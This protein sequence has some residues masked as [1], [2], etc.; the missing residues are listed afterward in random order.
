MS[1]AV[2]IDYEDGNVAPQWWRTFVREG[3]LVGIVAMLVMASCLGGA[4]FGIVR[5]GNAGQQLSN[6]RWAI[7]TNVCRTLGSDFVP[8]DYHVGES[9]DSV[10]CRTYKKISGISIVQQ[11]K[12]EQ[13]KRVK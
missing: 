10:H 9:T 12:S 4:I 5:S 13:F 8:E 1:I 2:S 7:A 3:H 6:R 11:D